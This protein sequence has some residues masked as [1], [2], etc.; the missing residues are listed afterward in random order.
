MQSIEN[1]FLQFERSF[2]LIANKKAKSY[3][4]AKIFTY[5]IIQWFLESCVNKKLF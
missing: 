5:N 2:I 1:S 4:I 3:E